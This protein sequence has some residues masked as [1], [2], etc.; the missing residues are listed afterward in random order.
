[1]NSYTRRR[2][3][4]DLLFAGGAMAFIAGVTSTGPSEPKSSASPKPHPTAPP[5]VPGAIAP[6]PDKRTPSHEQIPGKVAA[7]PTHRTGGKPTVQPIHT[8]K[9]GKPVARPTQ[10]PKE[11]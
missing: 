10:K 11:P 9:P 2:L 6:H 3:L 1:M 5:A 4:T 8:S 7:P